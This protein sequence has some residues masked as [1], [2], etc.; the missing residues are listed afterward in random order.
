MVERQWLDEQRK[1]TKEDRLSEEVVILSV[2]GY[3]IL[4]EVLIESLRAQNL[5][6][7]YQLVIVIVSVEEWLFTEDLQTNEVSPGTKDNTE[8]GSIGEYPPLRRTCTHSST[9]P[10]Y[11]RTPGNPQEAPVL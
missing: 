10:N 4:F 7:L 2:K 1:S 11:N 9:C 3:I 8:A 6:D 5:R